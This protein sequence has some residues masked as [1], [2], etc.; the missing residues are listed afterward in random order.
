MDTKSDSQDVDT[1][2]V[3]D[4]SHDEKS[5]KESSMNGIEVETDNSNFFL[6]FQ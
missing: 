1:E 3:T 4:N 2:E 5:E 6:Q